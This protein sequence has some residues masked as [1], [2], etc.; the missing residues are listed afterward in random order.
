M[1][2]EEILEDKSDST[3]AEDLISSDDLA[4]VEASSA[5]FS[6]LTGKSLD[7]S[8]LFRSAAYAGKL[9]SSLKSKV[10]S[11]SFDGGPVPYPSVYSEVF[12]K[13]ADRFDFPDLY[14]VSV[15][16]TDFDIQFR[17][18]DFEEIERYYSEELP[19]I[20]S[21]LV[22][23]GNLKVS[24]DKTEFLR[25]NPNSFDVFFH[26]IKVYDTLLRFNAFKRKVSLTD[27][28]GIRHKADRWGYG[29]KASFEKKEN[30]PGT[31]PGFSVSGSFS[32]GLEEYNLH[33]EQ[34]PLD[35]PVTA[36]FLFFS[37]LSFLQFVAILDR[38]F[39]YDHATSSLK[40]ESS[41]VEKFF[42]KEDAKEYARIRKE[43]LN[44]SHLE[45]IIEILESSLEL[46]ER[47]VNGMARREEVVEFDKAVDEVMRDFLKEILV[48][49]FGD[50][51]EALSVA[52]QDLYGFVL[53]SVFLT[54][55][56]YTV[57]GS[58]LLNKLLPKKGGKLSSRDFY[59][60]FQSVSRE[61]ASYLRT[62][63]YFLL[64]NLYSYIYKSVFSDTRNPV[65]ARSAVDKIASVISKVIYLKRS[66]TGDFEIGF[67]Y[68][69]TYSAMAYKKLSSGSWESKYGV[70]FDVG[71]LLK[72]SILS[73][74]N[75]DV[76]FLTILIHEFLHIYLGHVEGSVLKDQFVDP[77]RKNLDSNSV[78]P[79]VKDSY[80]FLPSSVANIYKDALINSVSVSYVR[81][82]L[83]GVFK[84]NSSLFEK[85]LSRLYS[86]MS[87]GY[88]INKG[89]TQNSAIVV[90]LMLNSPTV[91]KAR[92]N[93]ND[94]KE[95]N[96]LYALDYRYSL[97]IPDVV[98]AANDDSEAV[99]R[100]VK[101]SWSGFLT[102]YHG[103][104][105]ILRV[106]AILVAEG[107][108]SRGLSKP[109]AS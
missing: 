43:H 17:D 6:D 98:V 97:Y 59:K 22:S 46:N 78:H 61:V 68:K 88:F 56:V 70:T 63:I 66:V 81:Q 54:I 90:G 4:E 36:R 49:F 94:S 37:P 30:D 93:S 101:G 67:D 26:M 42:S 23:D 50:D 91:V 29:F 107:I 84:Y 108:P 31:I 64:N 12:N 8:T 102:E 95:K 3:E 9:L 89:A 57:G 21:E 100:Y 32:L 40:F 105:T 65:L 106:L 47:F 27:F 85:T 73:G 20:L 34:G 48:F 58:G 15:D 86:V 87:G 60:V 39:G 103:L 71:Y 53:V 16:A 72:T 51:T 109:S 28:L 41:L 69:G 75:F 76:L 24:I 11:R 79:L 19:K 5:L 62:S 18:V 7:I 2:L 74:I 80:S 13:I 45:R 1:D 25:D 104:D 77:R 38:V 10:S 99:E 44:S 92:V 83:N 96:K 35:T 14:T 52:M 55:G 82:Y 33:K